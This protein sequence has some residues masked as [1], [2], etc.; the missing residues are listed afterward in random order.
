MPTPPCTAPWPLAPAPCRICNCDCLPIVPL[1]ELGQRWPG[2][3]QQQ[4]QEDDE[5]MSGLSGR[6]SLDSV[7]SEAGAAPL[8]LA[9]GGG[10]V[11]F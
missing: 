10:D 6:D 7:R 4:Q 9:P 5:A 1:D 8:Q 2:Q 3:Q 11:A